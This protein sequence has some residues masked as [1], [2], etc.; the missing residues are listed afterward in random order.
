MIKP[1][2][3]PEDLYPRPRSGP[4]PLFR[5]ED[6]PSMGDIINLNQYRKRRAR[7][8]ESKKARSNRARTGRTAGE[9]AADEIAGEKAGEELEQKRL[10]TAGDDGAEPKPSREPPEDGTPTT[11]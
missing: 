1:Y 2:Q 9:K 6:D 5:Q 11:G 3:D 8:E 4:G 7:A 10:S